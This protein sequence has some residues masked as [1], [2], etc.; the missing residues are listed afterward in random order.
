MLGTCSNKP[1]PSVQTNRNQ[2][3][4]KNGGYAKDPWHIQKSGVQTLC[5]IDCSEW[6]RMGEVSQDHDLCERCR[7]KA[8]LSPMPKYGENHG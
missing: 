3:G 1:R 7:K 2:M 5:G 4:T 8:G 6:L